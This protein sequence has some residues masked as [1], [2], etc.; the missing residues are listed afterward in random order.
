MFAGDRSVVALSLPTQTG[1]SCACTSAPVLT[2]AQYR[3]TPRSRSE[4]SSHGE[5]GQDPQGTAGSIPA[6]GRASRPV[7]PWSCS[8]MLDWDSPPLRRRTL[9]LTNL[10]QNRPSGSVVSWRTSAAERGSHC[11]WSSGPQ[12]RGQPHPGPL[13]WPMPSSASAPEMRPPHREPSRGAPEPRRGSSQRDDLHLLSEDDGLDLELCRRPVGRPVG[14]PTP[15]GSRNAGPAAAA[16]ASLPPL[17][18]R[19]RDSAPAA[20]G[21]R[22][23]G[24]AEQR[25]SK[26]AG[27]SPAAEGGR[28]P[29]TRRHNL[30]RWWVLRARPGPSHRPRSSEGGPISATLRL[31]LPNRGRAS[32][33]PFRRTGKRQTEV[34]LASDHP[35][36]P[37][38]PRPRSRPPASGQARTKRPRAG[39]AAVAAQARATKLRAAPKRDQK[40]GF[41]E[42]TSRA[43][44][45]SS[46]S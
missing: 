28:S 24:A 9:S 19:S 33:L 22:T 45:R 46:R 18:A 34:A 4:G 32:R 3:E 41:G 10:F 8:L 5:A 17:R 31:S 43:Q 30:S 27:Q 26:P 37:G 11:T 38:G 14:A 21:P 16:L 35:R 44:P 13:G 23:D 25:R 12:G 7:T 1:C 29:A 6:R 2:L 39:D 36:R 40:V 20:C 42:V 15:A